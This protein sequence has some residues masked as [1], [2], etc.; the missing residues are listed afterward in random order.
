MAFQ[1]ETYYGEL[2][3]MKF[4]TH[5][6]IIVSVIGEAVGSRAGDVVEFKVIR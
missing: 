5:H 2:I 6:R 1:F 4:D 3:A